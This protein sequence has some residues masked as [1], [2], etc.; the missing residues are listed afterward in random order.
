MSFADNV[1][2][3]P[4]FSQDECKEIAAWGY[5]LE[6]S[7]IENNLQDYNKSPAVIQSITT[8]N[9]QHYNFFS[10][11]P[12]FADR[13]ADCL[14]QLKIELEWPIIVQSWINIYRKNQGIDWHT[15]LGRMGRSFSANIFIA[16]ENTPTV[17]YKPFNTKSVKADNIIGQ[18]HIFPCELFHMVPKNKSDTDRITIGIT[19]H[20][21]MDITRESLN[22]WAF[23]S[24]MYQDSIILTNKHFV[25]N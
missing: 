13:F 17:I 25:P 15:H 21:Y 12:A 22:Q 14:T 10:F 20:S 23:N 1:I 4:F 3:V 16:G 18:L 6:N 8:A 5:Q 19:C 11:F 24:Q 9:Y 2:S 7:L